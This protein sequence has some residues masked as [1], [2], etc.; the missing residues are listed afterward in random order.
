VFRHGFIFV[1]ADSE[2]TEPADLRGADVGVPSYTMTAA[3]WA[4]GILQHEYG[5]YPSDVT[6]HQASPQGTADDDPLA[7]DYPEGVTVAQI[8]DD[9]DLSDLLAAGDIDALVSPKIP[10]SYDGDRVRRLFPNYRAVE[11]AYYERTGHFPIMHTLVVRD[12]VLA[13]DPWIATE[14]TALFERAKDLVFDELRETSQRRLSI[15]WVY[16]HLEEVQ[17]LMGDEFWPY[18]VN[19]NEETLEAMTEFAH[20][21]GFT[22]E[23]ISV[24]ELFASTS[25]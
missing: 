21:Q 9:A 23:Q 3:L 10:T 17:S 1:N 19:E 6:W 11:A 7:F 22:S 24:D 14:L 12:D 2:I 8:P 16:Q 13:D 15:P 4:R 18:G 20:E 25:Y 5:L